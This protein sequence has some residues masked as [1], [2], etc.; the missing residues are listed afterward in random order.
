MA[1]SS[2]PTSGPRARNHA[3]V[4]PAFSQSDYLRVACHPPAIAGLQTEIPLH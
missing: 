4:K 2:K 1:M 3:D